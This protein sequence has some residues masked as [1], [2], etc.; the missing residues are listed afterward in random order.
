MTYLGSRLQ[1]G[2]TPLSTPLD[3]LVRFLQESMGPGVVRVLVSEDSEPPF[4]VC[5]FHPFDGLYSDAIHS[6][7][8]EI[9]PVSSCPL[10]SQGVWT[11]LCQRGT[12]PQAHGEVLCAAASI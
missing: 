4:C 9:N 7:A 3:G 1:I 10:L 11:I 8:V 5:S 2:E 12:A 6:A